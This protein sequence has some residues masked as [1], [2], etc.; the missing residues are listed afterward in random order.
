MHLVD[1]AIW[2]PG[3]EE[4]KLKG[5]GENQRRRDGEGR[6]NKKK[7]SLGRVYL[8]FFSSFLSLDFFSPFLSFPSLIPLNKLGSVLSTPLFTLMKFYD[9]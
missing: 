9:I 6:K 1:D 8:D 2:I 4:R 7:G 5:K 3:R